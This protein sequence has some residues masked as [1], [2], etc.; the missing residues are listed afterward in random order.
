[1][2]AGDIDGDGEI[3]IVAAARRGVSPQVHVF[4]LEGTRKSSFLAYVP[5][6]MGGV[7]VAV[8]DV[9]GDGAKDIVTAPMAGGGPHVRI[10]GIDG[11]VQSQF[12]AFDERSRAGVSIAVGDVDGDGVDEIIAGAGAGRPPTVRVFRADGT[13]R[14]E[15]VVFPASFL[16]GVTVAAVDLDGNGTDEI[17][18]GAGKGG[19]PQVRVLTANGEVYLQFFAF[20]SAFRGGVTVAAGDVNHD[21]KDELIVGTGPG[22]APQVAV[23]NNEGKVLSRFNAYEA[24]FRQ[25]INVASGD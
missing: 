6:F 14:R 3:D 8:G 2:A 18:V 10:F 11:T 1:V 25:G 22:G 16:G 21:G 20:S 23:Y 9:D 24:G 15:L 7:N 19:G 12:F 5:S 17:M 13:L 4:A